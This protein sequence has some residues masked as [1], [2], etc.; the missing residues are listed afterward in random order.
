MAGNT[1]AFWMGPTPTTGN[2]PVCAKPEA[3]MKE[4]LEPRKPHWAKWPA[5]GRSN[6]SS[7]GGAA[8]SAVCHCAV[9]AELLLRPSRRQTRDCRRSPTRW[10]LSGT[11]PTCEAGAQW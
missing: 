7:G 1:T 2:C 3:V 6:T 4:V 8:A 5:R 10:N 9:T 11:A